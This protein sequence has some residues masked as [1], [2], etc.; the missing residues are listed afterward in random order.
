[1]LECLIAVKGAGPA[2]ASII[3]HNGH[4]CIVPNLFYWSD[5]C[6]KYTESIFMTTLNLVHSEQR[7]MV[8]G[9][10]S[11]DAEQHGVEDIR[12]VMVDGLGA[13]LTPVP[14]DFEVRTIEGP[15]GAPDIR[16]LVHRPETQPGD[17]TA[18]AILYLHGGGMIAGTAEM[19]AGAHRK[20]AQETGA[21]VIAPNYRLAPE[22]PFPAGL[23]DCYAALAWLHE[24]AADLGVNPD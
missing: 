5:R 2:A 10:F 3:Y 21:V 17:A 15:A 9:F 8:A 7:D 14:V 22:A 12:S 1:M 6:D 13:L 24:H 4:C 11:F 19:M 16:T 18:P 23:E 20:F